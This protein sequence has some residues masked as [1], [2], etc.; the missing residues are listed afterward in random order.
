MASREGS[1]G[2]LNV[3]I[4]HLTEN[5]V[6]QKKCMKMFINII[7]YNSKKLEITL[8]I[9]CINPRINMN[10]NIFMQ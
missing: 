10:F 3:K 6:Q 1:N 2:A 4:A 9:K 7:M 5:C 8:A